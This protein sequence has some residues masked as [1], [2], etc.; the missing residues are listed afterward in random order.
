MKTLWNVVSFLAVVHLLALAIFL[1]W[2]WQSKRLSIDRMHDAREM[3]AVTV[4]D[5]KAAAAKVAAEAQAERDRK[6]QQEKDAHPPLDSAT[7]IQ[8]VS[9]IQQQEEQARRRLEDE[10]KTLAQQL[11]ASTAQLDQKRADLE[12]Q[13]VAW[14]SQIRDDGKRKQDG[15]FLLAVKQYEQVSPKQGKKMIVELVNQK[16]ID[17]AV[18]Y[19]NA[20]NPRAA[21][22]ILKEFKTDPEITLATEL[23]EKLRTFG[24]SATKEADKPPPVP[25]AAPPVQPGAAGSNSAMEPRDAHGLANAH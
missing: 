16:Q 2:L 24:V 6:I 12:R 19:L 8:S 23:L 25:A 3:F 5:A 13:R 7:Q 15:Q 4:P 10:K 21:G 9:L 14:E 1:V 20:M 22:K 18:A 17:Q 11:A